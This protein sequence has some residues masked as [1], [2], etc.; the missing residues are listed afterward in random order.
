M[1][2]LYASD[3][4]RA[5]YT[6]GAA[7]TLVRINTADGTR[8]ETELEMHGLGEDVRRGTMTTVAGRLYWINYDGDVLSVP[9]AGAPEV[10]REWTIPIGEGGT[11][12]TVIDTDLTLVEY[13]GIPRYSQYDL[14]TGARTQGTIELPWLE[15][16]IGSETESGRNT[17]AI[18][19]IATFPKR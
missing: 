10:K 9:L 4:S 18:A 12:A 11:V 7:L 19:D 6:G 3:D 13:G 8:S 5:D 14:Q 15:T 17:Y 16:L 2:A 1:L